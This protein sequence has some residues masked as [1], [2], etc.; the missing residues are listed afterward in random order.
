MHVIVHVNACVVLYKNV[1]S[2]LRYLEILVNV[3]FIS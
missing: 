1:E 3:I 2:S